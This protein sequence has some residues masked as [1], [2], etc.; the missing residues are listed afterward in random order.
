MY[1]MFLFLSFFRSAGGVLRIK[2]MA[3]CLVSMHSTTEFHSWDHFV[4]FICILV[5]MINFGMRYI[6]S[7]DCQKSDIL[8]NLF[9]I[10]L[11]F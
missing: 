8:I 11:L 4:V 7:K 5:R 10:I 3:L 1:Y 6:S 2:P 9:D